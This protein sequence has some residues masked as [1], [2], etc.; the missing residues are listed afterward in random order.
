MLRA[1]FVVAAHS[2]ATKL[3]SR[4]IQPNL[5]ACVSQFHQTC[6]LYKKR[7]KLDNNFVSRVMS[8]SPKVTHPDCSST[9]KKDVEVVTLDGE[10][11][12]DDIQLVEEVVRPT[13]EMMANRL[14]GKGSFMN[15]S[16]KNRFYFVFGLSHLP[17]E[18]S[19]VQKVP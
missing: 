12:S 3:A 15:W 7:K 13:E 4:T 2:K 9:T 1:I 17:P 5:T 11:S 19:T 10:D 18:L 8:D 14:S 16:Q 6:V